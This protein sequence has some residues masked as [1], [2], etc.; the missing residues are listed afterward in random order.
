MS[1][2]SDFFGSSSTPGAIV[3]DQQILTSSG[4]WNKPAAGLP[5]DRVVIQLWGAG[6]GGRHTNS[7]G[8]TYGGGGGAYSEFH[9]L[10]GDLESVIAGVVGAG[11]TITL[12]T[13][14]GNGGDTLFGPL[15]AR[16]GAGGGQS[17]AAAG[18][19]AETDSFYAKVA[20][21][22][23]GLAYEAGVFTVGPAGGAAGNTKQFSLLGGSGGDNIATGSAPVAPEIPGGG[24]AG[25]SSVTNGI[26]IATVGARGEIRVTVYRG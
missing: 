21:G 16:G 13:N 3:I 24:G 11:G 10:L 20:P 1:N 9:C 18:G 14:G 2:F 19:A 8:S 5:S 7:G 23:A 25:K 6:G 17:A 22:G 26:N 12:N 4:N 15:R